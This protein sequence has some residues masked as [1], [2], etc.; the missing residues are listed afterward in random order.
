[1]QCISDKGILDMD[2][3]IID[4]FDEIRDQI[5][6]IYD[7]QTPNGSDAVDTNIH[8]GPV[9]GRIRDSVVEIVSLDNPPSNG[10]RVSSSVTENRTTENGTSFAVVGQKERLDY[11]VRSSLRSDASTPSR[12]RVTLSPEV[13]KKLASAEKNKGL[14]RSSARKSR[15]TDTFYEAKERLEDAR[16]ARTSPMSTHSSRRRAYLKP[17]LDPENTVLVFS[18]ENLTPMGIEVT[19]VHDDLSAFSNGRLSAVQILRIE[20]DGRVGMDGRLKVGDN[21]IEIDSRPVYQMSVVRARAYLS[22]LQSR[23]E[24]SL[25]VAR[26]P[27]SFCEVSD[28]LLGS[29]PSTSSLHSRPI[30][31]AL[32]QANTQHIGHTKIVN[33][34]KTS[35]GFGFTVTGRET[36]K[37]ERLFYIGTVKPNGIALGHLRAGDRL[38][39]LN[40]EPTADLTQAE[41]VD[42][43]KRAGVGET[44]SFLVSRVIEGDNEKKSGGN[45]VEIQPQTP[46]SLAKRENDE[47]IEPSTSSETSQSSSRMEELE[48][49]IPLN[50]TGSA[51]LGVSL[52]ARVTVR[53][54]GTRQDCGIFIKNVLH[55]GAA[56]KDGR[57]KVNDRI[58]GI[59]E[60]RLDGETNAT[61]SEAVSRRLKAIGPTAKHVRLLI[62]RAK[63]PDGN[64]TGQNTS[65]VDDSNGVESHNSELISSDEK[66]SPIESIDPDYGR[67]DESDLTNATGVF[68]RE[69]PSRKSMSEK[70]GMGASIDPHHIKIFQDIK[71]QRETSAPN[72][73]MSTSLSFHGQS[74]ARSASQRAA[75]RAR[76]HSVHP[77]APAPAPPK[78]MK[79]SAAPP[80]SAP[81]SLAASNPEKRRSLSVE[82][83]HQDS[84]KTASKKHSAMPY[85]GAFTSDSFRQATDFYGNA[86]CASPESQVVLKPR[87]TS[88]DKDKQRRKSLGGYVMKSQ[89][90]VFVPKRSWE[91]FRL[92]AMKSFLGFGGKNRDENS[93]SSQ[94]SDTK[95]DEA[96]RSKNEDERKK[97]HD[98]FERLREKEFEA[99][100]MQNLLTPGGTRREPQRTYTSPSYKGTSQL[101]APPSPFFD[102]PLIVANSRFYCSLRARPVSQPAPLITNP[103]TSSTDTTCIVT[104]QNQTQRLAVP[105]SHPI[106]VTPILNRHPISMRFPAQEPSMVTLYPLD[107]HRTK[108]SSSM[109]QN[110]DLNDRH[111]VACPTTIACSTLGSHTV[112]RESEERQSSKQATR[113][114]FATQLEYPPT[115]AQESAMPT[116]A[117]H[118]VDPLI[119]PISTT[120]T[121]STRQ[122]SNSHSAA[123]LSLKARKKLRR[124][125]QSEVI[126][127]H[128]FVTPSSSL[129]DNCI[130]GKSSPSEH[131]LSRSSQSP[132]IHIQRNLLSYHQ[133]NV[134]G[135]LQISSPCNHYQLQIL[136][137]NSRVVTAIDDPGELEPDKGFEYCRVWN[138]WNRRT[139]S[140]LPSRRSRHRPVLL[141]RRIYDGVTDC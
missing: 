50:D 80:V 16:Q 13:E 30:L 85:R 104:Q 116:T 29:H 95:T 51:G 36:A 49:V 62:H 120:A 135:S 99:N 39:E 84:Q 98:H 100:R 22:E 88:R 130:T 79:M 6:A 23:T 70:R 56:H 61:A 31:S 53:S 67:L 58:V 90:G 119:Q 63:A 26:P 11:P 18:D 8:R 14:S 66:Q 78:I 94:R 125:V 5:L 57:L 117:N 105:E 96:I 93:Y 52:K 10:L 138:H 114:Q 111:L 137:T 9:V 72:T 45:D 37:G 27:S 47:K 7:E 73:T 140:S 122:E 113:V 59:E 65:S 115:L 71:H 109:D 108:H 102:L 77:R 91:D 92:T 19:G 86:V 32:Q 33:L 133:F 24:P 76:S 44:V 34:K 55:G 132:N 69:A 15:L 64:A 35:S 21:I 4:V 107:A 54:N 141:N 129:L 60:L 139:G 38:L 2:D 17:A 97:V 68:N 20:P 12:H 131:L 74:T 134:P 83:I 106:I 126:C 121:T 87:S 124:G 89:F 123:R 110:T 43:L 3:K 48:L 81:V 82:S 25:T 112:E 28:V 118:D 128:D 42:R 127:Q 136:H 101:S 46:A 41:V 75:A 40:G 103:T 1:M